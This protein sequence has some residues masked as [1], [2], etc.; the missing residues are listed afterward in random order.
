MPEPQEEQ[1]FAVSDTAD[2]HC[3]QYMGA[4]ILPPGRTAKYYNY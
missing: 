4:V 1:N 2:P 3:E